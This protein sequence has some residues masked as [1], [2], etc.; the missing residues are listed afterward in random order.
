MRTFLLT[1]A[2]AVLA[3]SGCSSTSASRRPA[4]PARASHAA[5]VVSEA[6]RLSE[7]FRISRQQEAERA[8]LNDTQ[9]SGNVVR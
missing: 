6:P 7:R 3:L 1:V 4:A 9:I 2:A 8:T 5:P